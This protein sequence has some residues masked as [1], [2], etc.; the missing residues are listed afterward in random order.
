MKIAVSSWFTNY[1]RRDVP[2]LW[3]V[4]F[5]L[6]VL[7]TIVKEPAYWWAPCIPLVLGL[8]LFSYLRK[9]LVFVSFDAS[10]L[11]LKQD[12]AEVSV[13][14]NKISNIKFTIAIRWGEINL[15]ENTKFGSNVI[16]L[17]KMKYYFGIKPELNQLQRQVDNAT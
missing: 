7:F 11:Y 16:F 5:G 1:V 13:P 15:S 10:A 3:A 8:V 4:G 17:P 6:G 2:V 12:E 14:F 9:I